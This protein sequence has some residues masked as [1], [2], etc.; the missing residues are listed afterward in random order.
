VL[1]GGS[2]ALGVHLAKAMASSG[3]RVIVV[4]GSAPVSLRISPTMRWI[5]ADLLADDVSLPDGRVVLLH[6]NSD[7]RMESPWRLAL[8]NAITTAR[9]APAL[10][11][12]QVT[13]ISSVDVY[14][15][16]SLIDRDELEAWCD[17]ARLLASVPC[18]P[19]RA[20]PLCRRLVDLT[21]HSAYSASRLA[22]EY[23]VTAAVSPNA[24]T[25]LRVGELFGPGAEGIVA[26]LARDAL[27]GR[28]APD[29]DR[30]V[31]PFT[32]F[33]DVAR[34]LLEGTGPGLINLTHPAVRVSELA[35]MILQPAR[36]H[37][38][39]RV[40]GHP[41]ESLCS[42]VALFVQHLRASP[43]PELQATL[44]VVIPPR[45]ALPDIVAGRQQEALWTGAV[46]AGN[47]WSREL[48]ERLRTH[49]RLTDE[50]ALLLT[51]SGTQALRLAI[52]ALA[53]HAAPGDLAAL[54]SFTYPT[55]AEVLAQ[56]GYRLRFVDVDEDT[57]TMDPRALATALEDGRVRLVVAVDTFGNPCHYDA[58]RSVCRK[59]DVPLIG[60]SAAGFGAR[61]RHRPVGT[62]AGAHAFSM[63]FAK[64][65]SAAGSGGAV[66]LPRTTDESK[67]SIWT[68][69]A[70]MDELHAIGALDQFPILD[71]LVTRRNRVSD[72]YRL[73]VARVEGV[74]AQ[75]VNVG[76]RHSMVHFVVRVQ[77]PP[78]RD[79]LRAALG[80]L[81][82]ETRPYFGAL[83]TE[84]RYQEVADEKVSP[85]DLPVTELLYRQVLALPMSSELSDEDA[86][87]VA[88]ALECILGMN[89][90]QG[91]RAPP[92]RLPDRRETWSEVG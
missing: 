42:S 84:P 69:S 86:E 23:L 75:R 67:L 13:L 40:G 4:D 48:E 49:L 6:G 43:L 9:L 54:P 32:A 3:H 58:L 39:A 91:L 14:E 19:W 17:E 65:L 44:P 31:G 15:M 30:V 90:V 79:G 26:H 7:H 71:D 88:V 36:A 56:M 82:I 68:R 74:E 83:H 12:R 63:S 37:T 21:G 35:R 76:D 73:A 41:T 33:D 22:Q 27:A 51:S 20:A 85:L 10:F 34:V 11:G 46:K 25:V 70:L 47:R 16:Q 2:G 29:D 66:V 78:G 18:P 61:H 92:V 62:Q 24:L 5:E 87:K 50:H 57:W 8:D 38:D 60:D 81:G 52:A 64:A 89:S 45:P 53:G 1:V 72:R 80:R 59:A 77:R 55:T 28:P